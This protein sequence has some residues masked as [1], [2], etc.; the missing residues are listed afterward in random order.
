[1]CL[2]CQGRVTIHGF[3]VAQ[4]PEEARR[5]LGV[6]PQHDILFDELSADDHLRLACSLRGVHIGSV[7]A[8][9][10]LLR[11]VGLAGHL[12]GVPAGQL[13]SG[14]RRAL[15]V[16]L[17]F[18]GFVLRIW[19][20]TVVLETSGVS[21]WELLKKY[22]PGR[23]LC[24][25]THYMDE[26][27]MLGDHVCI[28]SRGVLQCYG[29]PEWLKARLGSGYALTLSATQV[30]R[31]SQ[32]AK[33]ALDL[34]QRNAPKDLRQQMTVTRCEGSEAVLRVPFA[35]GSSFPELLRILE[36]QKT[37]LGFS[38]LSVSVAWRTLW[39]TLGVVLPLCL[40]NWQ[41]LSSCS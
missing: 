5:F 31:T 23:A 14:R 27:E 30:T 6:C 13:S 9:Q 34:L 17:A 38:S 20:E 2:A 15:C 16:A 35:V 25:S 8:A 21:M 1:M 32:V 36:S 40:R 24:L 12:A 10:D 18:V 11:A 19:Q 7:Q 37:L 22:R 3:D 26:A 4:H 29:S 39:D 41:V 28:L 33:T